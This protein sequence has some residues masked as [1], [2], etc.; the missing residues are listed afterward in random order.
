MAREISPV[1]NFIFRSIHTSLLTD[2]V[3]I[4]LTVR[5]VKGIYTYRKDHMA[6]STVFSPW[7]RTMIPFPSLHRKIQAFQD[8][9][10][11]VT[12][13]DNNNAMPHFTAPPKPKHNPKKRAP[14]KT[15]T[16]WSNQRHRF[17][18]IKMD[19]YNTCDSNPSDMNKLDII[20]PTPK[21]LCT[22]SLKDCTYCKYDALHPSSALSDWSS[23]D[24]DGD[25]AKAREQGS[26]ID[27][28][29][30]GNQIQGTIQDTTQDAS[31]DKQEKDLINSLENLMLE[32]D[33]TTPSVTDTLIPQPDISEEKCEAE[34]TKD[35]DEIPTYNMTEQE[36]RLQCKEEKY[37]IYM[38]TFGCEGEDSDLDSDMDMDTDS[39]VM[40]Y[41]FLE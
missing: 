18:P 23:E 19:R 41:P 2:T 14:G 35:D 7:S 20:Q 24:W 27:F 37:G 17:N 34:G 39:N 33:K 8:K 15:R 36:Q 25:K 30:L 10:R 3:D 32:Q 31:Q 1:C 26:L 13:W 4:E 5:M 22:R 21:R 40:A 12:V 29:L 6:K 9:S 28:K 38:S 16:R 11:Q